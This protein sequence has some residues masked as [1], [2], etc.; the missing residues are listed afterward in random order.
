[1]KSRKKVIVLQ[2]GFSEEKSVSLITGKEIS[3]TLEKS[4]NVISLDPCEFD[5]YT[6]LLSKIIV[7]DPYVVF[8]A[9]HGAE[10]ED[11]KIQ[12]FLELH[13][14]PFTGSDSKAS[15]LAMDKF[16]SAK[17]VESLA[18][19]V[20]QKMLIVNRKDF[21]VDDI[22]RAFSCPFV[23]KPNCSGSSVGISIV[24]KEDEVVS[25]FDKAY[26][27]GKQVLI[28]EYICGRE[29]TVTILGNTALPVVEIV[30]K[31]G[32]Y[33]FTNKY[34]IGKTEYIVP[35]D[36]HP[37]KTKMIQQYALNIFNLFQ[38][39]GYARIDFRYDQNEF[40]FLEVNTL[41]G[42]TPLSLTPMAAKEAGY[43][44]SNLLDK[45]IESAFH[46]S[47]TSKGSH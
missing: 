2:G 14:I 38:C 30:P 19:P 25:A 20:P 29:L 46:C 40:Y 32:W 39:N 13:D 8:N 16:L 42:M 18:Y 7:E 35:A 22:F 44:F 21:H 31:N 45:I 28:E 27:V 33:D 47:S 26:E 5:S 11:G 10:G 4:Y 17:I 41:P 23:I 6:S 15:A 9:L 37:K 43:N 36:L 1:M 24:Q 34:T 3:R 12:A